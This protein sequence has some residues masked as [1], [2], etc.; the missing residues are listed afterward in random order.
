MADD[1]DAK[2]GSIMQ[3]LGETWDHYLFKRTGS[4][5]EGS[6]KRY[7]DGSAN[8]VF[9]NGQTMTGRANFI[10][11]ADAIKLN[12]ESD[13]ATKRTIAAEYLGKVPANSGAKIYMIAQHGDNVYLEGPLYG[14][15]QDG[16]PEGGID[17]MACLPEIPRNST[18]VLEALAT[19]T[20]DKISIEAPVD[21]DAPSSL[22]KH[23]KRNR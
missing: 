9:R 20:A 17:L 10:S 3:G 7:S 4:D 8:I 21:P 15:Q 23:D 22:I 16:T 12:A 5:K 1:K 13:K 11:L 19:D 6:V 14:H 18:K 2:E